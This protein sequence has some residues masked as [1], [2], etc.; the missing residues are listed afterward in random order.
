MAYKVS[1]S[2]IQIFAKVKSMLECQ[3]IVSLTY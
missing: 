1:K 3:Q 2:D